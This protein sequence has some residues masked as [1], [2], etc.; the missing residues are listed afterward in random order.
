MSPSNHDAETPS[1]NPEAEQRLKDLLRGAMSDDAQTESIPD[2]LEGVQQKLRIRS[3]GKFYDDA[4]STT[5][6][7][8]VSTYLIT[9]LIMLFVLGVS[10]FVLQPLSGRPE[11]VR[12]LPTPIEVI[13]PPRAPAPK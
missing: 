12:N 6:H 3:G 5:R 9:S 4:W 13:A 2:V 10:Y 8:P 1:L 7:A 11:P